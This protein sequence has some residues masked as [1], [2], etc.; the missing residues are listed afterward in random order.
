MFVLLFIIEKVILNINLVLDNYF[1]SKDFWNVNN[2][3]KKIVFS[4]NNS[5]I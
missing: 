5:K 3:K 2:V 4:D 1:V